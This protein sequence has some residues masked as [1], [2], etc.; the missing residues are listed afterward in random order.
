[1]RRFLNKGNEKCQETLAESLTKIYYEIGNQ[2]VVI[3]DEWDFSD[4][5]IGKRQA[6]EEY[7]EHTCDRAV[8]KRC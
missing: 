8:S 4:Q 1:M 6:G 3:F 7:K 2:F 5:G